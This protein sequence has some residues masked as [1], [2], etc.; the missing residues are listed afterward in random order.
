MLRVRRRPDRVN[1]E[2]ERH[3]SD[4]IEKSASASFLRVKKW[5][6]QTE[7]EDAMELNYNVPRSTTRATLQKMR[8]IQSTTY[9]GGRFY[10]PITISP[11]LLIG[12]LFSGIMWAIYPWVTGHPHDRG[13][14]FIILFPL[15]SVAVLYAINKKES[16]ICLGC[17]LVIPNGELYC[18]KECK[19]KKSL[20]KQKATNSNHDVWYLYNEEREHPETIAKMVGM[21]LEEVNEIVKREQVRRNNRKC[22]GMDCWIPPDSGEWGTCSKTKEQ[23]H[24]DQYICEGKI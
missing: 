5:V 10:A 8:G 16:G 14:F 1:P 19:R 7:I 6:R 2:L 9:A 24:K 22:G 20:P 17:G 11:A 15:F 18:S 4:I 3:I 12:M 13:S 21:S 23:R